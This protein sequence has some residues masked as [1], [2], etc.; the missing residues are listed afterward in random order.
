MRREC[1]SRRDIWRRCGPRSQSFEVSRKN[2]GAIK[3]AH[4]K[5][6]RIRGTRICA[7][8]GEKAVLRFTSK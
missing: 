6:P 3:A 8:W 5:E 1:E 4:Q 7:A 2:L